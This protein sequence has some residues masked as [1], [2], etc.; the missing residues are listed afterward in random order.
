MLYVCMY[1]VCIIQH[2]LRRPEVDV[3]AMIAEFRM[4][5]VLKSV[6]HVCGSFYE[7]LSLILT[8]MYVLKLAGVSCLYE[9]VVTVI[10][11]E[12]K[13]STIVS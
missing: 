7:G 5:S 2:C 12:F 6:Q 1:V 3:V 13:V 10:D 9:V 11:Y 4:D 8:H